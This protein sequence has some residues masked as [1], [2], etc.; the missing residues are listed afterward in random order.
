M[1]GSS[2]Q[3]SAIRLK[4]CNHCLD[5]TFAAVLQTRRILNDGSKHNAS[6][7][8]P[9]SKSIGIASAYKS[10]A[11]SLIMMQNAPV[12]Q[13][14]WGT[15]FGKWLV[16]ADRHEGRSL[17]PCTFMM[18]GGDQVGAFGPE[19]W[20]PRCPCTSESHH[21]AFIDDEG[22]I[23]KEGVQMVKEGV[24]A[25]VPPCFHNPCIHLFVSV[26]HIGQRLGRLIPLDLFSCL[27]NEP[28]PHF[29]DSHDE[30]GPRFLYGWRPAPVAGILRPRLAHGRCV[31]VCVPD[32]ET[33][34]S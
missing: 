13:N 22:L 24:A 16:C 9:E 6:L 1:C 8:F 27:L 15:Y 5:T 33:G 29:A 7:F 18:Q 25:L 3:I 30:V 26:E 12:L 32:E 4:L 17:K 20:E 14:R 10:G 19:S 21:F 23:S 34:A 11:F 31:V 28:K 2:E